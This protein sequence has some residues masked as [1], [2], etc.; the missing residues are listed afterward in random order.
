[1][2]QAPVELDAWSAHGVDLEARITRLEKQLKHSAFAGA[3]CR[4]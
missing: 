3:C 2:E 1:M 4:V